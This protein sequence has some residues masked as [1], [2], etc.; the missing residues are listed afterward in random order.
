MLL[1]IPG[2]AKRDSSPAR[3]G[4]TRS[5]STRSLCSS[6]CMAITEGGED[7]D[8]VDDGKNRGEGAD[9]EEREDFVHKM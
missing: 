9:G 4:R 3:G 7:G 5:I 1:L 6:D 2:G 8:D